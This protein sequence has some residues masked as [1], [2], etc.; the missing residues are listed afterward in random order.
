MEKIYQ[1]YR[2]GKSLDDPITQ[3]R[4]EKS[5]DGKEYVVVDIFH[6]TDTFRQMDSWVTI[7]KDPDLRKCIDVFVKH[8][9]GMDKNAR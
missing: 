4:I 5:G 1:S 8:V 9:W 7:F 6:T 2:F 3:T